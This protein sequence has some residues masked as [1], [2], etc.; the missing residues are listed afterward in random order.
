VPLARQAI[1]VLRWLQP[2]SD[3]F[4]YVFPSIR[5]HR[6]PLSDGTVN[7]ALRIMGYEQGSLTGHGFRATAR[8]ILDEVMWERVDLIEHQL[9]HTVKDVHG[10]AYN[11]TTHLAAKREMMQRCADYLAELR[12]RA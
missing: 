1:E 9:A 4:R 11:R 10:R 12:E 7:A 5:D 2:L 3:Q 8:T 6:K